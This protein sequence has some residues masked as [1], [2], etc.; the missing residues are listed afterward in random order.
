MSQ[1]VASTLRLALALGLSLIIVPLAQADRLLI[2]SLQESEGSADQRPLH[3]QTMEQVRGRFGEPQQQI[4]PVGEP[5]ITR[6]EYHGFTVYF[7]HDR[8]LRAVT[9]RD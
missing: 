9:H 8:V 3:G 6:W 4:V 2:E 7:E 5:P 1:G